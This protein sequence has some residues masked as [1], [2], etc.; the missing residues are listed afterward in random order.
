[1][2]CKFIR[3]VSGFAI[4]LEMPGLEVFIL[5]LIFLVPNCKVN[6]ELLFHVILDVRNFLDTSTTII[7]KDIMHWSWDNRR[8]E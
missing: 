2:S 1:M 4:V 8:W 5:R 3:T 6:W 7:E